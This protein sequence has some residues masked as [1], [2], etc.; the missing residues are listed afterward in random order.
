[1]LACNIRIE[2]SAVKNFYIDRTLPV[3]IASQLKGQIEY[4][5]AFGDIALG[6]KLPSVRELAEQLQISP[7][8]ILQV[9]KVLQD[10]GV[11]VTKAGKGTFVSENATL[12]EQPTRQLLT[13]YELIYKLTLTAREL[14]MS[15]SDLA[16]LLSLRLGQHGSGKPLNLFLVGNF[17]QATAAY[18]TDLQRYLHATDSL[19]AVTFSIL[20][21]SPVLQRRLRDA[22]AV[23]TLAYRFKEVRSLLGEKTNVLTLNFLPSET[24]RTALAELDP[25][26]RVGLVSTYADF[27]LTFK[28]GVSS[29]A[30]HVDIS[31]ATV[32]GQ[33]GDRV[34]LSQCDVV[35][36]ATGSEEIILSLPPHIQTLEYRYAPDPRSVARDVLPF[37]DRLRQSLL[38]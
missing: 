23:L 32:L 2:H 8:T 11:L 7:V 37:L 34:A 18:A 13:L 38:P 25:L 30:P 1:V 19:E 15:N 35:I 36:Y 24:T 10:K 21:E 17:A 22:D 28:H 27:L 33:E 16:Q 3:S 12:P 6:S 5:I 29:F 26:Q 31:C 9:Y 4:G 20:R 14:S